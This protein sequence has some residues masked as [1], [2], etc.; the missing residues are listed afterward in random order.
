MIDEEELKRLALYDHEKPERSSSQKIEDM[1]KFTAHFKEIMNLRWRR[2]LKD[3]SE[4]Y[5]EPEGSDVPDKKPGL[6]P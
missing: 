6:R 5:R 4:R 1:R 3:A 2:T